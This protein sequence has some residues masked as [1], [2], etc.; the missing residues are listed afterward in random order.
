MRGKVRSNLEQQATLAG[1]ALI[2][3]DFM[4]AHRPASMPFGRPATNT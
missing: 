3:V 4:L 1:E 2:S